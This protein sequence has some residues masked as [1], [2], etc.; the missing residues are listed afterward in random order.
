MQEICEIRIIDNIHKKNEF[1]LIIL[2][3]FRFYNIAHN[4]KEMHKMTKNAK[5]KG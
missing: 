2:K 1:R 4:L 3:T 5:G